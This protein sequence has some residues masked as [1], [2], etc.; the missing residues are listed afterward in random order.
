MMS[1]CRATSADVRRFRLSAGLRGRSTTLLTRAAAR[2]WQSHVLHPAD[3]PSL[4]RAPATAAVGVVTMSKS[5]RSGSTTVAPAPSQAP[6][7]CRRPDCLPAS[8]SRCR[9]P[10]RRA[11]TGGRLVVQRRAAD[12]PVTAQRRRRD[13]LSTR[14]RS[15]VH[16]HT[17]P[18]A[19]AH[20]HD[21]AH[22]WS[23]RR[24][25]PPSGQGASAERPCPSWVGPRSRQSTAEGVPAAAAHTTP[26]TSG[27]CHTG[28]VL[29]MWRAVAGCSPGIA[30]RTPTGP[31][32]RTFAPEHCAPHDPRCRARPA[33]PLPP[34]PRTPSSGRPSFLPAGYSWNGRS[35]AAL[36]DMKERPAPSGPVRA[37]HSASST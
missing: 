11:C 27:G 7:R 9:H 12:S 22:H 32:S 19:H 15:A 30:S 1:S 14:P 34:K 4:V 33:S 28:Y 5:P 36:P 26:P 23:L 18:H 2:P 3:R 20:A 37:T 10:P 6:S 25:R 24:R 13:A 21:E 8:T 16:A 17:Q 31:G 29:L 35:H